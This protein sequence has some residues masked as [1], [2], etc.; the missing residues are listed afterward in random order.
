MLSHS[1]ILQSSLGANRAKEATLYNTSAMSPLL[2]LVNR[3]V[4]TVS[5][6]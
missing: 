4:A 5:N 3:N 1:E 6:K 2:E